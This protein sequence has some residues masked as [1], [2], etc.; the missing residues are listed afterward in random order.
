M[1]ETFAASAGRTSNRDTGNKPREHRY[2]SA[3]TEY[4]TS[5]RLRSYIVQGVGIAFLRVS[6]VPEISDDKDLCRRRLPCGSADVWCCGARC[7]SRRSRCAV[8]S[9]FR[10]PRNEDPGPARGWWWRA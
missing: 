5:E 7:P 6:F 3:A 8:R 9:L 2:A 10:V 1:I 4:A